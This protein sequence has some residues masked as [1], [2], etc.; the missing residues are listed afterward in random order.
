MRMRDGIAT[1]MARNI[2][3][4]TISLAS[5]RRTYSGYRRA[6]IDDD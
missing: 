2:A 1:R 6:H 4:A 5:A 3:L